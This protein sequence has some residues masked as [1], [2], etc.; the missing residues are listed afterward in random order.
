MGTVSDIKKDFDA[1][2]RTMLLSLLDEKK[3]SGCE[4]SI[5][6]VAVIK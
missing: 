5:I 4:Y 2:N 6:S 1:R 3:V